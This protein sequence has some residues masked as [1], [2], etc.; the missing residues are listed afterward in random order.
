MGSNQGMAGFFHVGNVVSFACFATGQLLEPSSSAGSFAAAAMGMTQPTIT[1]TQPSVP[2]DGPAN[3]FT[4]LSPG[5]SPAISPVDDCELEE[6]IQLRDPKTRRSSDKIISTF[7]Q[8][9]SLPNDT[10][11]CIISDDENKDESHVDLG[12]VDECPPSSARPGA[13]SAT[14]P[15]TRMDSRSSVA[16][17]SATT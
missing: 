12:A 1:M 11:C 13:A 7:G 10:P 5:V 2:S 8:T 14:K 9:G 17:S 4:E 3:I 16:S 6:V 15:L